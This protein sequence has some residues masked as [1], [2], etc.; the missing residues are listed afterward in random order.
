[1]SEIASGKSDNASQ[2]SSL[3]LPT[4]Y[5]PILLNDDWFQIYGTIP[6]NSIDLIVT[7][8]PYDILEKETWD[9]HVD[10]IALE[11]T[12]DSMLTVNGRVIMFCNLDLYWQINNT[13]K[14]FK[15]RTMHIWKKTSAMPI[16]E[17]V[18]L[19]D[20]EFIVVL[21]RAGVPVSRLT[22]NPWDIVPPGK[23][24]IKKSTILTSPTRRHVKS[25][26]SENID[27]KRWVPT[28][29]EAPN[30]P[31]MPESERS[32]HP[33]Q[34]P[35]SLLRMLI[36]G[37]SDPG[38][39]ILDCFAGSGST[40]ISAYKEGRRSIGVE[41]EERFFLEAKSRISAATNQQVLA[42]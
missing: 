21:S 35:E 3:V 25:P 27:G 1:M 17:H 20:Y 4:D 37:Y 16:S 26:I 33:V 5:H 42:L 9:L 32:N 11:Q 28:I 19:P 31:N 7:D 38:Q 10:L 18:P 30:K 24:Y 40:L 39:L 8:P 36:R 29:L 41:I 12:F 14:L 13:F 6:V 23:P 15:K 34:K 22:W 2:R